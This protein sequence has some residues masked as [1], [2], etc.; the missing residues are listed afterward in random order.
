MHLVDDTAKPTVDAEPES[1]VIKSYDLS[2]DPAVDTAIA[3]MRNIVEMACDH[4]SDLSLMRLANLMDLYRAYLEMAKGQQFGVH[5]SV[6]TL[7]EPSSSV[8]TQDLAHT[9]LVS[10]ER[11]VRDSRL[12][13]ICLLYTSPSPRDRG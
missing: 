10:F 5:S 4:E 6:V 3:L 7:N 9:T 8:L 11:F 12:L 13:S 2:N 1:L